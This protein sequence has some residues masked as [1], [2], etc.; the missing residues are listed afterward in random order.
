MSPRRSPAACGAGR[1]V[2]R[3]DEADLEV[4]SLVIADAFHDLAPSRWLI[5]D[6]DARRQVF[7]GYFR[8]YLKHAVASGI[9]HTNSDRTAAALWIPSGQ[10]APDGYDIRLATVTNPW[11]SR[12]VAFD[13]AL[14]CHH[15]A[16][17]SHQHLAIL[18]VHPDQQGRG[19]GTALL[20]VGH[21]TLDDEDMPSYLE[22]SDP[23]NRRVYLSHGYTDYGP[24]IELPDGPRMYPM[25]RP[26]HVRTIRSDRAPDQVQLSVTQHDRP[27]LDRARSD[28]SVG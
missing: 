17:V 15:P 25:W 9:V 11:T 10:D 19:I 5:A 6:P 22:A 28:R 20:H 16:G 12:F 4:L 7:P 21:A 13:A 8:L 23:R 18:A 3:A 24:P 26:P 14:E 27:G 2:V 1:T